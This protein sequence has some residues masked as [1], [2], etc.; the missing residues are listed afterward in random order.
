[1]W[2]QP[3][4]AVRAERKLRGGYRVKQRKRCQKRMETAKTAIAW[5]CS[6]G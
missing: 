5:A 1:V 3:L 2:E 4:S 6:N